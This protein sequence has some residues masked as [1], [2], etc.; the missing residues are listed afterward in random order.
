MK[1]SVIYL[2]FLIAIGFTFCIVGCDDDGEVITSPTINPPTDLAAEIMSHNEIELTWIDNS[3]GVASFKIYRSTDGSTWD[4]PVEIDAGGTKFNDVGLSEGTTYHYQIKA[5]VS[6]TE[7]AA[8]MPV[9][10]MTMPIA[11]TGFVLSGLSSSSIELSWGDESDVEDGYLLQRKLNA[12]AEFGTSIELSANVTTYEDTDIEADMTY[13]YRLRATLGEISSEWSD[14]ITVSVVMGPSDLSAAVVSDSE[15][16]LAWSDNSNIETGF[17]LERKVDGSAEWLTAATPATNSTS[18]NDTDLDEATSY[19]YR[20]IAVYE[21]GEADTTNEAGATTYPNAPSEL[22]ALLEEGDPTIVNLTW[23]DNSS[24][25]LQFELQRKMEGD[26]QFRSIAHPSVDATSYMDRNLETNQTFY[27]R[28]RTV[29]EGNNYS[30]WSEEVGITTTDLTPAAPSNLEAMAISYHEIALTWVDNA[31]NEETFELERSTE[32]YGEYT[33]IATLP[34]DARQYNDDELE[35]LTTYYYKIRAFN[36]HGYSLYSLIVNVTTLEGPPTTPEN[37]SVLNYGYNYVRLIWTDAENNEA[38][39]IFERSLSSDDGWMVIDTLGPDTAE[40]LDRDNIEP[41]TTYF[42]RMLAYNWVG[43][44]DYSNVVNVTTIQGPPAAPTN[45]RQEHA[46]LDSIVIGWDD[47]AD[48]ELGFHVMK[49]TPPSREFI[50]VAQVDADVERY[51]DWDIDPDATYGYLVRAYSDFGESGWSNEIVVHVPPLPPLAPLELQAEAIG[52]TEIELTWTP[53]SYD[54]EYFIIEVR[55][56]IDREFVFIGQTEEG[57]H[58]YVFVDDGVLPDN[59][60]IWYR[61]AAVNE[62]GMSPYSNIV[63]TTTPEILPPQNLQAEAL[64]I[65][66]I[67]IYW[68]YGP[69]PLDNFILERRD[70]PEGDFAALAEPRDAEYEDGEVEP[71]EQTYWYRVKSEFMEFESDWSDIIEVTTPAIIQID[72]GFEDIEVGELPPDPPWIYANGGESYCEVTDEESHDG[73]KSLHFVDPDPDDANGTANIQLDHA[74]IPDGELDFWVKLTPGGYWGFRGYSGT[75]QNANIEFLLQF[76]NDGGLLSNDGNQYRTPDATW[77][78]EDWF[79]VVTTWGQGRFS[80][81]F[82]DEV[83]V[84]NWG[85]VFGDDPMSWIWFLTFS[86]AGAAMENAWLDDV[87]I[88]YVIPEEERIGPMRIPNTIG[89]PGFNN[90]STTAIILDR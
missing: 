82:N 7:S 31:D 24:A 47:N 64:D 26:I 51:M 44:S 84:D 80:I 83:I 67:Y 88:S 20:I 53:G 6:G 69:Y 34:A 37:L 8:S 29:A 76:N 66:L 77:E 75:I 52:L 56:Q 89:L 10:A 30:V 81:Y 19:S 1:R 90:F 42:Y 13:N 58:D 71:D 70:N 33:I 21:A 60:T 43:R 48:D 65:A 79:H 16:E 28:I 50:L 36:E 55:E 15:I 17:C 85:L 57:E 38:G 14:I 9:S 25:E 3:S 2:V 63:E 72:E 62:G 78:F 86:G 5:V 45:L 27:Y 23:V 12:D 46:S 59:S 40:F 61:V 22:T 49:R 18:Y 54:E 73:E 87:L 74:A 41:L 11:P 35:A 68:D 32:R 4:A 39:F